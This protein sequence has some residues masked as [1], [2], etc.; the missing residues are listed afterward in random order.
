MPKSQ[1][2]I[3]QGYR[4]LSKH[5]HNNLVITEISRRLINPVK[6]MTEWCEYIPGEIKGNLSYQ[7]EFINE[8]AKD[9]NLDVTTTKY[10]NRLIHG[11]KNE[12]TEVNPKRVKKAT[13]K[14]N[15]FRSLFTSIRSDGMFKDKPVGIMIFP[16]DWYCKFRIFDGHHRLACCY[17]LQIDCPMDFY[18]TRRK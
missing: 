12:I 4:W 6:F 10:W 17:V 7:I 15:N 13:T 14:M 8:Y 1:Q 5:N 3:N 11:L 9:S 18:I 16:E 2:V